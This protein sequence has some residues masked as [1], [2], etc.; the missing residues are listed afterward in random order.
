M[1]IVKIVEVIGASEKSFED[2]IQNAVEKASQTICGIIGV[3]VMRHLAVVV[4]NKIVEYRV[5]LKVAFALE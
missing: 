1:S 4:N 5:V 2:A 3:Y